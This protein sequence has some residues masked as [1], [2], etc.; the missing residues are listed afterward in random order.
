MQNIVTALRNAGVKNVLLVEGL[1]WG[2]TLAGVPLLQDSLNQI[3]Y[4]VHPYLPNNGT[5]FTV[6]K[7]MGL[8]GRRRCASYRVRVVRRDIG[9]LV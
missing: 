1:N 3:V 9:R 6:A 5:E 7:S 4:A 8:P 2:K